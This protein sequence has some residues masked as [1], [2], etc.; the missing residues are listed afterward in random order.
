MQLLK[1]YKEVM[2]LTLAF[3]ISFSFLPCSCRKSLVDLHE[4]LLPKELI[5]FF[6]DDIV[7]DSSI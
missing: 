7:Y 6:L 4:S 1:F 5:T 2:L 3:V